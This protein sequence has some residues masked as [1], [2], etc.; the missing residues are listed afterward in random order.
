MRKKYP[1]CDPSWQKEKK[2]LSFFFQCCWHS[3]S[4]FSALSLFSCQRERGLI[5]PS[6]HPLSPHPSRQKNGR[7]SFQSSFWSRQI[8]PLPKRS[9]YIE[10]RAKKFFFFSLMP[11]GNTDGVPSPPSNQKSPFFAKEKVQLANRWGKKSLSKNCDS[12]GCSFRFF[13]MK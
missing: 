7:V 9:V 4:P 10:S 11:G 2:D 3:D 13:E 5:F 1:S 12:R 6:I 8:S